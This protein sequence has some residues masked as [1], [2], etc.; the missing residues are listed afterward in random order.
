MRFKK[1]LKTRPEFSVILEAANDRR[2]IQ[3]QQSVLGQ[4]E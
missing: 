3:Q 2:R 4:A 1:R